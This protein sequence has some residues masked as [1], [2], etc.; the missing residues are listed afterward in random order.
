M[1]TDRLLLASALVLW[2]TGCPGSLENKEDFLAGG[3]ASAA[4]NGST[5]SD[6]STGS[7][8]VDPVCDGLITT[9]CARSNCHVEGASTP[10]LT[11]E[12]REERLRDVPATGISCKPDAGAGGAGG[13]AAY[14]LVDTA[15][16]EESLMYT[17]C[18]DAPPC[19]SQMPLIGA[20]KLDD[21][22]LACLLEWISSL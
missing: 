16:P 6:G 4:S 13:Q 2:A 9:S 21:E 22:Q 10:D 12:G 19:G 15:N 17:K 1:S 5:G 14:L 18:L 3:G 11:V 8:E 20:D 7:G